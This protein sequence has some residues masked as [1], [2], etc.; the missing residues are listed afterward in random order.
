MTETMIKN[1]IGDLFYG[2]TDASTKQVTLYTGTGGAR[3]FDEAL[4]SHFSGNTWKLAD[5][6]KF[7]TGSGRSMGLTG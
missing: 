7:I 3:E 6:S 5:N 2:M 1:I 4:K